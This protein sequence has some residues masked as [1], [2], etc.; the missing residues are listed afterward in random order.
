MG[1]FLVILFH[2]LRMAEAFA[3]FHPNCLHH[4]SSQ[5]LVN[6]VCVV[7]NV[8]ASHFPDFSSKILNFGNSGSLALLLRLYSLYL[9]YAGFQ[10]AEDPSSA[11]LASFFQPTTDPPFPI[12]FLFMVYLSLDSILNGLTPLYFACNLL[13]QLSILTW[14]LFLSTQWLPKLL[15]KITL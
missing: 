12:S 13:C 9:F 3:F 6:D 15:E 11:Y 8:A 1:I 5:C 7:Y 2:H 4:W 10:F 14:R